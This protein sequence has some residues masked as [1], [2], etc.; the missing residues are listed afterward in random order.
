MAFRSDMGERDRQPQSRD[1]G[2]PLRGDLRGSLPARKSGFLC[3]EQGQ[4]TGM[5]ISGRAASVKE[6]A[7]P[8]SGLDID[9]GM[10]APDKHEAR[11]AKFTGLRELGRDTLGVENGPVLVGMLVSGSV[12]GEA[13]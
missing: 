9:P 6:V 4:E 1:A 8:W 12:R 7:V 3:R 11:P 10:A 5:P 2:Q 13:V